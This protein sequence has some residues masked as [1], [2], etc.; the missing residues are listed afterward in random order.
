MRYW[1][2]NAIRCIVCGN[3]FEKIWLYTFSVSFS[4]KLFI[5]HLYCIC[6][7][8]ICRA[9]IN[10]ATA[11][12][13]KLLVFFFYWTSAK[14]SEHLFYFSSFKAQ[15]FLLHS[16]YTFSGFH[17]LH[18]LFPNPSFFKC[19][20]LNKSFHKL[21]DYFLSFLIFSSLSWKRNNLQSTIRLT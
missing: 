21:N 14:P 18:I 4:E 17:T 6:F 9:V 3:F 10:I 2:L 11:L 16:L 8:C 1:I 5:I 20:A 12:T 7:A 15:T 13:S 19:P